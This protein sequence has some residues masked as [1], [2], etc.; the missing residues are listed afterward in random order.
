MVK[1]SL[2]GR[3]EK[4]THPEIGDWQSFPET[5]KDHM[6][7]VLPVGR[8]EGTVVWCQTH[9]LGLLVT[10]PVSCVESHH[11]A[12]VGLVQGHQVELEEETYRC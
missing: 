8:D 6:D 7:Q 3:A 10:Q 9:G 12:R 11:V 5:R 4:K 2:S 1:V